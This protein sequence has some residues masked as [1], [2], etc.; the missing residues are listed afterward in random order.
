MVAQAQVLLVHVQADQPV[1]AE[2]APVCEPV[3]V[4]AGLAEELQLHLLE[5]AGAEGEVAGRDLVAEAL[6]DLRDAE[7][8]LRR[9][10][11]WIFLKLTKMPCAV[12]GRR[13]TSLAESSVTPWKVLNI[14]LNL[15]MSV[16][17]LLPQ[18]GQG[19]LCS[20]M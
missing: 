14:R 9:V 20:R 8:D 16:K 6:A 5:L 19:M 7:G 10:V 13:Y 11:R 18:P 3:E 4:G 12:S 17:S 2:G 15:R 1:A